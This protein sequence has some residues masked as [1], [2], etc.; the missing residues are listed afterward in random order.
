MALN[1]DL[2]KKT[3]AW[4][5]ED[6]Q[7]TT[8]DTLKR[9]FTSYPVFRNPDPTKCYIVDADASAYAIRATVSKDFS[10][11][12]HPI[13]FFSKSLLLAEPNYDIYDRELLAIINALKANCH[14]LLGAQQKFLIRTDHNNLK[15]FK[16]PQKISPRQACWHE[17]LQDYNF[18]ITHFP[19]KSNTIADLLSQRKDFEGGVNPN[20][21]VT[22]LPENLFITPEIKVNKVYLE[23]NSETRCK[24]LQEIYDAPTGGHPG[25]SNTWDLVK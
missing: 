24:V 25:I 7:Q 4:K 2:T 6:N 9:K 17:F 20:K 5:W 3:H 23:D 11:G 21:D 15:Y 16:T 13:T 22:L 18:E 10:D 19:G 14:L 12:R 8:F 1:N